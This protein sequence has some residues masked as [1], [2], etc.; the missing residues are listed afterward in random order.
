MPEFKTTGIHQSDKVAWLIATDDGCFMAQGLSLTYLE[1][2]ENVGGTP[3]LVLHGLFGS[4]RNW[5]SLSKRF[6]EHRHSY[7]LDMRNHGGAPWSDEMDYPAMAADIL[8]FMD[9][10]GFQR[11]AILG[12]SMGGKAAMTLALNH[13]GRV[14]RLIVADIAPVTYQ[15]THAPY[16]A[17]MKA[18][19]LTGRTRRPEVEAQLVDAVPEA[20]LRSFLMQNLVLENGAFRWRVNL[21]AIGAGMESLIGFPDPGD[22]TYN[23]PALFIGGTA[24]DY[25]N[26]NSEPAIRRHFPNAKITMMPGLGHWLHAEKPDQFAELVEA[27]L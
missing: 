25:I 3:L 2:G 9:D 26:G 24:S 10:R 19:D 11:A 7:T 15:H 6:G 21:D 5:L 18:A 12:H 8:R 1:N 20:P 16:V 23:G 4:A 17:A 14:E 22:A 13:P 27:F